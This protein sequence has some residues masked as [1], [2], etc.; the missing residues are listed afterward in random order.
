[1]FNRMRAATFTILLLATASPAIINNVVVAQTQSPTKI[2]STVLATANGRQ[3]TQGMVNS[4]LEV[5]EFIADHKFSAAEKRWFTDLAI[6]DFRKNTDEEMKGYKNLEKI[7]M[8]IK[9]LRN[10]VKLAQARENLL[11]NIYLSLLQNNEV[12]T[13][14]IWTIVYKYSPVLYA[15]PKYKFV[16]T[17]RTIDSVT[18]SHNLVAK[19]AGKPAVKPDYRGWKQAFEKENLKDFSPEAIKNLAKAESRWVGL[20]VS[21]SKA[22]P[23]Q[24]RKIVNYIKQSMQQRGTTMHNIATVLESQVPEFVSANS[25]KDESRKSR[26]DLRLMGELDRI[27]DGGR[28]MEGMFRRHPLP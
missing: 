28:F 17:K 18:A 15:N 26:E 5:G 19:I 16:V 9:Q 10:P 6:K 21:L 11:A 22:S 12:N 8:Q 25:I 1:M 13:P 23:R 3:L 4:V 7:L 14:S 24:R 20:Q 2:A 27:N